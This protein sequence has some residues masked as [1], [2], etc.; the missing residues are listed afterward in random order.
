MSHFVASGAA[1]NDPVMDNTVLTLE[2]LL[3]LLIDERT[4]SAF[5]KSGVVNLILPLL[6]LESLHGHGTVDV[7]VAALSMIAYVLI[8]IEND[9]T[10]L[11]N[12]VSTMASPHCWSEPG[13]S[14]EVFR[15]THILIKS[16]FQ[17]HVPGC[18]GGFLSVIL[19]QMRQSHLDIKHLCACIIYLLL[20]SRNKHL[21][22][23]ISGI[24]L[25][26]VCRHVAHSV[27]HVLSVGDVQVAPSNGC[28]PAER[29][30][31]SLLGYA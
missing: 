14:G 6:Q 10:E 27:L 7:Q 8:S 4:R 25:I 1:A 31:L 13:Q 16:I 22:A 29:C 3:H 15:H 19:T 23:I 24:H 30:C 17:D 9:I 20:N 5:V 26:S 21:N 11:S 2:T 18:H 12:K 28:A